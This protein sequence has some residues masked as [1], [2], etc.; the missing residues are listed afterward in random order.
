M[1]KIFALML[2]VLMVVGLFA[3]CT[4]NK[5]D[6]KDD[7]KP[8]VTTPADDVKDPTESETPDAT[9]T[10]DTNEGTEGNENETN[11]SEDEE[12]GEEDVELSEIAQLLTDI[13][14]VK[15]MQFMTMVMDVDLTDEFAITGYTGLENANDID[16]AAVCEAAMGSQAY[17]VVLV[18]VKEGVDT[19]AVAEAMHAGINPRKWICVE[20]DDLIVAASGE[21]VILAMMDSEYAA[22]C[23]AQDVINAFADKCGELSHTVKK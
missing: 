17:S 18:K 6:D 22:D 7:T 10:P 1:K 20:A 4:N 2:A 16:V 12:T 9:E 19:K 5:T 13:T 3:G 15:P 14:S 23:T 8:S 11:P 21:Y